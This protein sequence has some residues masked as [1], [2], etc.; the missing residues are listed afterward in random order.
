MALRLPGL[1][2]RSPEKVRSTASGKSRCHSNVNKRL[3]RKTGPFVLVFY[4]QTHRHLPR[5]RCA[6]R[7]TDPVARKRCA[8]PP[9]GKHPA[10]SPGSL[11]SV[12]P[13]TLIALSIIVLINYMDYLSCVMTS[14][15]HFS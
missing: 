1:Q 5:W 10:R 7:G 8:A 15:H 2:S 9:P 6:Y 4:G 3:S 11:T 12:I 14:T 13:I